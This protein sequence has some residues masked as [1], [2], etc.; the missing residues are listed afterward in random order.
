MCLKKQDLERLSALLQIGAFVSNQALLNHFTPTEKHGLVG[1]GNF[2][3]RKVYTSPGSPVLKPTMT[4]GAMIAVSL[5]IGL[6]LLGLGCLTWYIYHVPS[7]TGALDAMA[8]AHIGARL[9]KQDIL[10]DGVSGD[11]ERDAR[12]LHQ[13]DGLI[14]VVHVEEGQDGSDTELQQLR[15]TSM[16]Q[17][18]QH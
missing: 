16:E 15:R 6:Q 12:A 4:T 1:G 17:H 5:L 14:G 7:W 18:D 2:R 13:V 10:L 9:G 11:R 8:V 3:G